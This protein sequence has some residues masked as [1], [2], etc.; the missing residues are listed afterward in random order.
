MIHYDLSTILKSYV[1]LALQASYTS[2][3]PAKIP[4]VLEQKY[5]ESLQYVPD[6]VHDFPP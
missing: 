1:P 5:P 2:V 6:M 4:G 3:P